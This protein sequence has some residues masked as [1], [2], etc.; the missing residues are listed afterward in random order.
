MKKAVAQGTTRATKVVLGLHISAG[1]AFAAR[2]GWA[3]PD[4]TGQ[5]VCM[6]TDLVSAFSVLHTK[7]VVAADLFFFFFF[8]FLE[9][10]IGFAQQLGCFSD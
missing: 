5:L 1:K 2:L 4:R 8:W 3:G 6:C 9:P 10:T 7:E